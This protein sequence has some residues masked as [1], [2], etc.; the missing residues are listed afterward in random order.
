MAFCAK[1]HTPAEENY[2]IYDQELGAIAKCLE[3][4]RPECEGSVHPIEILTDHKNLEYLMTSKLF[5]RRQ[6]RWSKFLS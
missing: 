3:Q 2:T 6:M 5:C 1:Q 4:W